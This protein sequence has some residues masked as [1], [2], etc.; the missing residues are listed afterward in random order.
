M[1]GIR[2]LQHHRIPGGVHKEIVH[3]GGQQSAVRRNVGEL[4]PPRGTAYLGHGAAGG[5][6]R[7]DKLHTHYACAALLG[8]RDAGALLQQQQAAGQALAI[9]A[10]QQPGV[11]VVIG[12]AQQGVSGLRRAAGQL[13]GLPGR[14]GHHMGAGLP[15][16]GVEIAG[17]EPIGAA[18]LRGQG[19]AG[20]ACGKFVDHAAFRHIDASFC[21]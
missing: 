15:H 6:Q 4:Y 19:Q 9:D 1:P 20:A 14:K 21:R 11:P 17:T 2:R 12:D 18:L 16:A 7:G 10:V 8:R 5:Q 3:G 13:D